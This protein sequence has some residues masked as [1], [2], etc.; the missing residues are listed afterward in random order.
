MPS[1]VVDSFK[2]SGQAIG[3]GAAV[4][5]NSELSGKLNAIYGQDVGTAQQTL[6]AI[7]IFA[8]VTGAKGVASAGDAL[9]DKAI[10][11]KLDEVLDQ[12]KPEIVLA[13]KTE[14]LTYLSN[15]SAPEI[16]G[17]LASAINEVRREL[18]SGGNAAFA[19]INIGSLSPETMV[20]KAF[21]GFDDRIEEFLPKPQGDA[22]TWSLQPKVATQKY[23]DTPEG[24]LRDIDTEFKILETVSQRLKGDS[25]AAGSIN[26]ISEKAVC[27]SCTSVIEQFRLKYPK[28]Q[29]NV[30]TVE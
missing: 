11:K 30:F 8:A 25:L 24:Y 7:R 22:S 29:L 3:E 16:R 27:P 23:I 2:E 21:S 20:M 15:S 17:R 12:K 5:L 18:P 26:L 13:E 19:E 9:V 4:A 1:G 10:G 28:V 6:L 14:T